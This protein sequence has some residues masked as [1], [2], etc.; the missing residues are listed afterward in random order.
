MYLT[1]N[2]IK[3]HLNLEDDYTDDDVYLTDLIA[4]SEN[5]VELHIHRNL[6]DIADANGG[7]LPP[8]LV[9]AMK[10]L[11]SHFYDNRQVITPFKTFEI[12][13][14]YD[15]LLNFFKQY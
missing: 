10:L 4:V 9:H 2:E 6:I 14:S 12:S 11:I 1:I 3:K 5:S 13:K 8:S 7:E 15:Y